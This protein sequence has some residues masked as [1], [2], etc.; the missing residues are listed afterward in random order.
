MPKR[1]DSFQR[2]Q[3]VV[4]REDLAEG[5]TRQ[6]GVVEEITEMPWGTSYLVRLDGDPT[7][8][9]DLLREV[10]VEQLEAR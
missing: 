6:L 7:E 9:D 4:L 5:W 2:G 3:P 1:Q 10:T 8:G